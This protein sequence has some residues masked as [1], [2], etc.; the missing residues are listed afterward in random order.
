[1]LPR[2]LAHESRSTREP[3]RPPPRH[4]RRTFAAASSPTRQSRSDCPSLRGAAARWPWPLQAWTGSAVGL[5]RDLLCNCHGYV[6]Q[7]WALPSLAR[8]ARP[9]GP[10][11]PRR[12]LTTLPGAPA[13]GVCPARRSTRVS[14]A[15]PR[16]NCSLPTARGLRRQSVPRFC[17]YRLTAVKSPAIGDEDSRRGRHGRGS[18]PAVPAVVVGAD[19]E[20]PGQRG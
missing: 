13:P 9:R 12:A 17:S 6:G 14:C 4:G 16:E 15:R 19:A 18:D 5:R 2:P 8:P 3:G 11:R 10:P 20:E 7:H 1:V